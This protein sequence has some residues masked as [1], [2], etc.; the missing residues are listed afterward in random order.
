MPAACSCDTPHKD[1]YRLA[2]SV[3]EIA[4]CSVHVC[5]KLDGLCEYNYAY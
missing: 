3:K 4:V 5:T 2:S 1:L